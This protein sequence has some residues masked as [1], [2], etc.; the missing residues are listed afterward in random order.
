MS[1]CSRKYQREKSNTIRLREPVK[2]RSGENRSCQREDEI[3]WENNV[4]SRTRSECYGFGSE[5]DED[6]KL[7]FLNNLWGL[8]SE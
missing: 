6:P 7:E 1:I 3:N 4:R 8:G 2:E 5:L